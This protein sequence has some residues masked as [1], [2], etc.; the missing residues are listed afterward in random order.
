M[1]SENYKFQVKQA[2]FTLVEIMISLALGLL[3]S[4]AVVQ[5]MISNSM[6]EK[7]NRAVASAQES[8]R[9]IISR[10]RTDLLM[11]GLYDGSNPQLNKDVDIAEEESFLRNHPIP[12]AGDFT[13]RLLLGSSQGIDGAN[14]TLVVSLQGQK[15]CR[16]YSLGY[17]ADEE[18]FVVNEYFVDDGKLKCRGFDGRVVRGQKVAQGHNNHA[19]YTILD[20]VLSFQVSYGI[21]D[22]QNNNGETLP[23]K[24]I[25]ASGLRAAFNVN[26]QVVC[27][28]MAVVVKGEGDISLDKKLTFKLLNEDSFTAPDKGLYKAFETTVTLRNMTNFVRGSA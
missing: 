13:E 3:I 27:I 4:S 6:T 9:Y 25:D 17:D 2:G 1:N 28:R 10:M 20:D 19:A 5:V 21:A 18:F 23:V 26:Q 7:L 14:D 8:G 16:G 11:V 24:Y 12:V 15:D 22:P